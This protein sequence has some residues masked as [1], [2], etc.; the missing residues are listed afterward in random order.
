MIMF[1]WTF[2]SS[3]LFAGAV[4]FAQVTAPSPSFEVAAIKPADDAAGAEPHCSGGPGTNA[5]GQIACADYAL[6]GYIRRAYDKS[7]PW[8]LVLPHSIPTDR[9]DIIA[10][11]PP[12]V[13]IERLN[14]MFQNLLAERFGLV[15]HM[16][17]RE[18]RAYKLVAAKNGLKISARA[19]QLAP[20]QGRSSGTLLPPSM[21]PKDKDGWPILPP[22]AKGIFLSEIRGY[23]RAMFREQPLSELIRILKPLLREPV[24][25]ETSLT[26]IFSFDLTV[27][28]P[29]WIDAVSDKALIAPGIAADLPGDASEGLQIIRP[30]NNLSSMV[31]PILTAME[32]QLGLKVVRGKGPVEVLVVD[33]VNAK[34]TEN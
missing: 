20:T 31:E 17:K 3:L 14:L 9:Y 28:W 22:D 26:G 2:S 8:E 21:L 6:E 4:L 5:P 24:I 34:P 15:V 27:A 19:N 18:M 30:T 11:A 13:T 1:R 23:S 16:E 7:E 10:K 32:R 33:K 12:K 29:S 25:D